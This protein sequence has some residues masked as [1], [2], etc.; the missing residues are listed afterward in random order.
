LGAGDLCRAGW[1]E[2]SGGDGARS[3]KAPPP[4]RRR[5]YSIRVSR[6][7]A[8]DLP[9]SAAYRRFPDGRRGWIDALADRLFAS[10]YLD[11]G[12]MADTIPPRAGTAP[13]R[14]PLTGGEIV[15]A[16]YRIVFRRRDDDVFANAAIRWTDFIAPVLIFL[17][18][19]LIYETASE[20]EMRRVASAS[21]RAA[22]IIYGILAGGIL[23]RLLVATG[24]TW[25]LARVF[26]APARIGPGLLGYVWMETALVSPGII[27]VR[28]GIGGHD[29]VWLIIIGGFLPLLFLFYG[30]SRVMSVAF[31]LSHLGF[32][33]LF[34]VAGSV[35]SYLVERLISW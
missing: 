21:G 10:D 32:G 14:F 33:F 2:Q 30:A 29:P 8:D 28:S 20:P 11:A 23:L 17:A 9:I 35:I 24:V 19:D 3:R 4:R 15:A 18:L 12:L 5:R 22:L 16:I 13:Q 25:G 34:A 26:A 31:G 7:E 27:I 1:S 6:A